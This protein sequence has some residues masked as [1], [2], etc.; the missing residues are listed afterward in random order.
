MSHVDSVAAAN[1]ELRHGLQSLRLTAESPNILNLP[2]ALLELVLS[3]CGEGASV[4]AAACSCRAFAAAA[5]SDH[6]WRQLCTS[7]WGLCALQLGAE[8][9]ALYAER[10]TLPLQVVE[11]IN[12]LNYPPRRHAALERLGL[13]NR[14]FPHL[15]TELCERFKDRNAPPPSDEAE[16]RLCAAAAARI[17]PLSDA[18]NLRVAKSQLAVD[19]LRGLCSGDCADAAAQAEQL[20]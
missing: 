1:S 4:A 18:G 16:A 11:L 20:L 9:R 7:R 15:V 14:R 12:E 17:D 10:H 6:L 3:L 2:A 19:T 13:L 8:P 5:A